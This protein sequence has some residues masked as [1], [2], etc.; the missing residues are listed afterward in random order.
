MSDTMTE[1]P[2]R[3]TVDGVE[4]VREDC[5]RCGGRGIVSHSNVTFRSSRVRGGEAPWCFKCE[6]AGA[7]WT[8]ATTLARREKAQARAAAK[9]EAEAAEYAAK[10]DERAAALEAW[11]TANADLV[12]ALRAEMPEGV[13]EGGITYRIAKTW[14]AQL[15]V[16]LF[17]AGMIP[18]EKVAAKAREILAERAAAKAAASAAGHFGTVGARVEITAEIV[19]VSSFETTFGYRTQTKYVVGM[20]TA[21]GHELV[22]FTTGAFG[23][24]AEAGETVTF[25][26][27][28]KEHGEYDGK[29]Q[30]T[31]DRA[32][33]V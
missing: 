24:E 12:E 20:R 32:K 23:Y 28:V 26:A 5:G 4:Y 27:T 9:R 17:D 10:A 18:A 8:K 21:E 6:G 1:T 2:G 29:P 15:A 31:L 19:R 22:T 14:T 3:K 11:K 30:T 16:D 33:R 25:K 7:V 13:V